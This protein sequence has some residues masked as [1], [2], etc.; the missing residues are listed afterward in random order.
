[1]KGYAKDVREILEAHGCRFVRHGKGD[2]DIWES[3]INGHRFPWI[4]T[5]NLGTPPTPFSSKPGSTRSSDRPIFTIAAD[6]RKRCALRAAHARLQGARVGN[7]ENVFFYGANSGAFHPVL[8]KHDY[9]TM[10]L[11]ARDTVIE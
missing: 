10:V 11:S 7:K 5:S 9:C 2:H 3:P 6:R 4:T 1:V 8:T